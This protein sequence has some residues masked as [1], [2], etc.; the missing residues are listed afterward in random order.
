MNSRFMSPK[1]PFSLPVMRYESIEQSQIDEEIERK[2]GCE[3]AIVFQDE[4]Y[5]K[6]G[7][8]RV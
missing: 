6:V 7:G 4:A 8:I 1:E 3:H 5:D 2:A